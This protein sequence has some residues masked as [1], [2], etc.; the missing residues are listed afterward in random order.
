M[1][2]WPEM[3]AELARKGLEHLEKRLAAFNR[4]A[5]T[6]R[7]MYLIA[8]ALHD[9]MQGLAPGDATDAVYAVRQHI[10]EDKP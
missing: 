4:G 1:S 8:D 9:A 10:K 6:K 2:D 7:E 5:I 3:G